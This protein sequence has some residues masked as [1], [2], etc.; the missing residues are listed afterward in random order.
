MKGYPKT[1]FDIVDQSM[2]QEIAVTNDSGIKLLAMQTY[3][4]D[5]G[6]EDW[7]VINTFNN[8]T[9]IK[10]PLSFLRHGQSQLTV[11]EILRNG[12]AVLGKRMVSEDATLANLTVR[13]RIIVVDNV[14]YVYY[15]IVF[16]QKLLTITTPFPLPFRPI[17]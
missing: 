14:S 5:K 6:T 9:K 15:Y 1:R 4:S 11:A 2:I 7:E 16:V 17:V 13:A 3:T 8:F 12:G 10:G